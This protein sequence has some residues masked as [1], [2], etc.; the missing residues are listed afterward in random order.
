MTQTSML[1]AGFESTIPANKLLQSYALDRALSAFGNR[2]IR[3]AYLS[4]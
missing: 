1:L 4:K 2:Q 3:V